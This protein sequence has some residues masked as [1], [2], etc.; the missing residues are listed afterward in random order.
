MA[1]QLI[2]RGERTW[3]V[4]VYLGSDSRGKRRYLNK[5][6]HGTRKDA[7]GWLNDA[8]KRKDLGEAIGQSAMLCEEFFEDWL[9]SVIRQRVRETSLDSYTHIIRRYVLPTL[10]SRR[11]ASVSPADLQR[12]YASLLARGLSAKTV[13]YVHVL[14]KNAFKQAVRWQMLRTSPAQ[15]VDPPR[16]VRHEM[17]ALSADEA[18]RMLA[19][20]RDPRHR[21]ALVTAV[22]SGARP[23]EY[24]ALKWS[25]VDWQAGCVTIQRS[26]TWKRNKSR[27]WYF[28]EPKTASSRRRVPLPPAVMRQLAEHKRRQAEDRM[29]A[30]PDWQ[31]LDLVFS[32]FDGS[33][34]RRDELR[35]SLDRH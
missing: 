19:E 6:I 26:I 35:G 1:G 4:R 21:M 7:Q 28:S 18:K 9:G 10:G 22:A 2:R 17:K 33:P 12:L 24:M 3:L 25:D 16:Q 5:T 11:L 8:L 29:L 14:V 34:L 31:A 20:V 23:G 27:S 30:G 15:L 32:R 13:G